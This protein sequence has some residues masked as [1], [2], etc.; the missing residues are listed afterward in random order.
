[1]IC[2]V[3]ECSEKNTQLLLKLVFIFQMTSKSH[4]Y[5]SCTTC[6]DICIHCGIPKLSDLTYALPHILTIFEMKTLKI[7]S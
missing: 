7:Y 4:V 1:M 2:Q 6:F 5:L 3:I